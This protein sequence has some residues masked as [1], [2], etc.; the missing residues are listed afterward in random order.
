MSQNIP[1]NMPQ[2]SNSHYQLLNQQFLGATSGNP[3][4]TN[5][6]PLKF[7]DYQQPRMDI[8]PQNMPKSSNSILSSAK[9]KVAG[10]LS[11]NICQVN[12][13]EESI[14]KAIRLWKINEKD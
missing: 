6:E 11:K 10:G 1:Q 7:G 4:T 2:S 8:T 14:S 5:D 13:T 3:R 12:I 9:L